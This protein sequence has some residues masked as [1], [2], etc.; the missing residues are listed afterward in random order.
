LSI[1]AE[2]LMVEVQADVRD[3]LRKLDMVEKRSASSASRVGKLGRSMGLAFGGAAVV[4]GLKATIGLAMDF[5]TTIRQVGVQTDQSGKS[6]QAMSKL[7]LKMG[8]DT[9]YSAQ[10]AS[11]AMLGLAKGGLTAA[12]IKGGA[13]KETMTLAAAGG[14]ELASAADYITESMGAFGIKAKNANVITTALAGGANASTASVESLGLGLAQAAAGATNAGMS[15]NETVGALAAFANSGIRGSD[16]GTTLKTMLSSLVPSTDKARKAMDKYGLSFVKPNGQFKSMRQVAQELKEGLGGLGEAERSRALKT[17]FGSDATRA[18]TVLMKNGAAGMAKY[19]KATRNTKKTQEMANAAMT[20][21]KGAW[22]NL[23]GSVETAAITMGTKMLPAFTKGAKKG[24]DFVSEAMTWGPQIKDSFGWVGTLAS[25]LGS[26]IGPTAKLVGG[27]VKTFDSLPGP[28][29]STVTELAAFALIWPK[30]TRGAT[31]LKTSLAESFG[32]LG[33]VKAYRASVSEVAAAQVA[34]K[35]ATAEVTAA[36]AAQATAAKRATLAQSALIP[37]ADKRAAVAS[38]ATATTQLAGDQTKAA[39]AGERLAAVNRGRL[40]GAFAAAGSAA[41]SAAGPAGML[42]LAS[43][44]GKANTAM[45]TLGNIGGGALM[46]FSVGGPIGAAIGGGAG[47]LLSLAQNA[48]GANDAAKDG[49]NAWKSYSD[50]L[51]GVTAASGAATRA[52]AFQ[53]LSKEGLLKTTRALGYSDNQTVD[54]VVKGGSARA[55]LVSQLRSQIASEKALIS[56]TE[57]GA[58]GLRGAAAAQAAAK[59]KEAQARVKA[60]QSVLTEL[61]AVDKA[62]AAKKREILATRTYSKALATLPPGVITAV[63][64]K[65]L[66]MGD[67]VRLAARYKLMPKEVRTLIKENGGKPTDA[68]VARVIARAKELARQHPN[69]VLSARDAASGVIA[70]VRRQIS[71][72]DGVTATTYVKTVRTTGSGAQTVRTQADGG[73]VLGQRKPYGDKVLTM[74]APGEEVITNRNGEAD[75]FRRDRRE[76]RIPAYAGGGTVGG[77]YGMAKGGRVPKSVSGLSEALVKGLSH[78]HKAMNALD[79]T[80]KRNMSG[81]RERTWLKWSATQERR[82]VKLWDRKATTTSA[83]AT[84]RTDLDARRE[85]RSTFVENTRAGMA[86]QATV[87]NAGVDATSIDNSLKTQVAK[88]TEF[89]G[90]LKALKGM[91]YANS[92]VDQI[93]QAGVEGGWQAA[94]ALMASSKDQVGSINKSMGTITSTASSTAKALGSS[95]YDA[96]VQSAAGLVRGLTSQSKALDK[97]IKYLAAKMENSLRKHLKIHS[98][99]RRTFVP[100]QMAGRGLVNGLLSEEGRVSK[101]AGTLARAAIPAPASRG[102]L[103]PAALSGGSRAGANVTFQFVTHNPKDEPVSTT[104]N[105]AMARVAALG[106]V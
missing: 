87:L 83:L 96:G 103:T 53:R 3:A 52:V 31:G 78:V 74:L 94:K 9:V 85:Q 84:A 32:N 22:E 34:L 21:A 77:A 80:I 26:A 49:A 36:Q 10:D 99:S 100:G 95:M 93:G 19:E 75:R 63:K 76:G 14:L 57:Q 86:S 56:T 46:G 28:V 5:D 35:T 29:K 2:R 88:V 66:G 82:M 38:Y 18:A 20:G 16:A 42:L 105:N 98:P 61:G 40:T 97:A 59:A 92:V 65:V 67:I 50:S 79:G 55:A 8:K 12:Q 17:I 7:A 15:I 37:A 23:K 48:M 101:A 90:M 62:V 64:A 25:D 91:G 13:L 39:A 1:T 24:A 58:R 4:G 54:A 89:A 6:L 81:K 70:S 33:P 47:A 68:M 60:A 27:L 41:K 43:S 44:A 30:L 102:R 11:Q 45:G 106:L 73:T 71:S 51:D 104:T 69:V 72:L